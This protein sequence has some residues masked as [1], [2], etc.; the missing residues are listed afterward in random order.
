LLRF[1]AEEGDR[2]LRAELSKRLREATAPKRA[3]PTPGSERRTV[4]QLLVA[5]AALVEEKTRKTNERAARE[6]TRREREEAEARSKYLYNLSEREPAAWREVENLI[7]TKR[8]NDYDR[9]V[10]LLVD[11]RDLA[12]RAGRSAEAETRLQGLRQ[13][14]RNKPSLLRRFDNKRL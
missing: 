14:H 4:A 7:A 6:R 11:L 1:L 13:R 12:G 10:E 3:R 9:A 2:L 8:P 5:R